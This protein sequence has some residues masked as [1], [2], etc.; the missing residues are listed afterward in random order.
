MTHI[1]RIPMYP[2]MICADKDY[3]GDS[4]GRGLLLILRSREI[5]PRSW[6]KL[7]AIILASP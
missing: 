4:L 2:T 5:I 3:D 1:R 6:Y 7:L